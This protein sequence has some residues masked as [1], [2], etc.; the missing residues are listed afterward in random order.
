[1]VKEKLK[2]CPI[3]RPK[4]KSTSS[5]GKFD[6]KKAFLL[7]FNKT[8]VEFRPA[9]WLKISP[10]Y[11]LFPLSYGTAEIC[12]KFHIL[13]EFHGSWWDYILTLKGPR[14]NSGITRE[15]LSIDIKEN[16]RQRNVRI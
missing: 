4:K 12:L 5:N 16:T 10:L 6:Q 11:V 14:T 13:T 8:S 15:S 3:F 1:M 9:T 2:L 7:F